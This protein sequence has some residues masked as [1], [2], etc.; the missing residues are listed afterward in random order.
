VKVIYEMASGDGHSPRVS[1]KRERRMREILRRALAISAEEGVEALTIG[2]LAE[3]LDYTPGALYRY[4]A[5]K[6]ALVAEL[7]RSVVVFVGVAIEGAARRA[8]EQAEAEGE[9]EALLGVA[10]AGLAFADFARRCPTEFGLLSMYLSDPAYRL[11][12][13]EA[14]YV[15]AATR[16]ALAVLAALIHRA[17]SDGALAAGDATRRALTAWAALQGVLQ[18]RKL[19]RNDPGLV[20]VDAMAID[21]LRALLL[22]WGADA[23]R[24]DGVLARIALRGWDHLE[25]SP[26]ALLAEAG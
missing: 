8:S 15:H 18:T 10:V 2:R 25:G 11:P 13:E 14:G 6:D 23:A 21:L 4:F 12:A 24:V 26:D 19:E 3:D 7:Q 16:D 17:V 20:A 5:S 1:R 9:G 22:G